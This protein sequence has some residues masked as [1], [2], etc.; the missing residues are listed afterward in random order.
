M[1]VALIALLACGLACASTPAPQ[2]GPPV[3]GAPS[4][5]LDPAGTGPGQPAPPPG[6]VALPVPTGPSGMQR[7]AS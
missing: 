2:P 7:V 6:P 3:S 5:P 1:K 4:D